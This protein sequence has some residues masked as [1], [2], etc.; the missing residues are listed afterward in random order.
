MRRIDPKLML[1]A[2]WQ[3]RVRRRPFVLSH[4]VNTACNL[5]CSFCPHWRRRG[6]EMS[7]REITGMLDDA[8]RFGIGAYN[9]WATEPLLRD[10]LP[11]ILRHA[12]S[13][14]MITSLVTNGI[15]LSERINDLES[16]NYLTVSVD[17]IENLREIRGIP[18]D[19]IMDGI[20]EARR[21][22]IEVLMNCVIS[23]KNLGE[24]TSLVKLAKKIDAWI[25]FEPLH[26][27][28]ETECDDLRIRDRERYRSA[29]GE[30][31][32][33]KSRGAPIINSITYLRMIQQRDVGFRC[34]AA[35]LILHVSADGS[36]Y[37]CRVHDEPLGHVSNGIS[38]VWRES[39]DMRKRVSEG[40]RG[41]L[42][43]GYV[44]NSMLY[45]MVPEVM[46]HYEWM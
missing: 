10:D 12:R 33:L 7:L 11:E 30:L 25:S 16:L 40:C 27:F 35:D 44:E 28:D 45:E 20:V 38:E 31:I 36:I 8:S 4:T 1:R 19:E 42:F 2:V 43:F 13:L 3:L 23:D 9:A 29:I 26:E 17:G 32:D 5:R 37:V 6:R 24:L 15:L 18:L 14:G 39:R 41:C 46:M 22:G 21:R 34:H